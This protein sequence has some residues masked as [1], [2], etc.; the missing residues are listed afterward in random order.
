MDFR[1]TKFMQSLNKRE[2][3]KLNQI[4]DA[5]TNSLKM[6]IQQTKIHLQNIPITFVGSIHHLL[7]LWGNH[8]T[9]AVLQNLEA[10]K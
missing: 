6:A 1:A 2:K 9:L 4:W 5:Y 3:K 10:Q 8:S 7:Q